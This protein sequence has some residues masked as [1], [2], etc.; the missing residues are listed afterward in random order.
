MDIGM[1]AVSMVAGLA[2]GDGAQ[3]LTNLFGDLYPILCLGAGKNLSRDD[4]IGFVRLL[5]SLYQLMPGSI[6]CRKNVNWMVFDPFTT[7]YPPTGYMLVLPTLL[8][9]MVATGLA[10]AGASQ[11]A[12]AQVR[13]AV[14]DA[15]NPD[16]TSGEATRNMGTLADKIA[17]VLKAIADALTDVGAMGNQRDFG[18]VMGQAGGAAGKLSDA[19]D[20]LKEIGER[21]EATFVDCRSRDGLYDDIYTGLLDRVEL[22]AVCAANLALAYRFDDA[23]TK[24]PS[25]REAES[26]VEL[27]KEM[28]GPLLRPIQALGQSAYDWAF[29]HS[30]SSLGQHLAALNRAEE[31]RKR[32]D[33]DDEKKVKAYVHPKTYNL[34]STSHQVDGGGFLFP[35]AVVS[36]DDSNLVRW[37]LIPTRLATMLFAALG[38]SSSSTAIHGDG[39]VP[40]QSANPQAEQLSTAFKTTT[41]VETETTPHGAPHLTMPGSSRVIDLIKAELNDIAIHFDD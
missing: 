10:L 36:N 3:A 4:T 28:L 7:G 8:D 9:G 2:G 22:R 11:A 17:E 23:I 38:S 39:T 6:Y 1:G 26:A 12:G 25:K 34:Y 32:K 31:R 30:G 37:Q 24:S 14:N 16:H 15:L 41:A 5:P 33:D 27:L 29:G 35:L 19:V 20:G 21:C 40:E 13:S 18:G